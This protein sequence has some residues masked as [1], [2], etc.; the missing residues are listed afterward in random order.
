VPGRPHSLR[1]DS[2]RPHRT[3]QPRLRLR[4]IPDHALLRHSASPLLYGGKSGYR[5]RRCAR[6]YGTSYRKHKKQPH[7]IRCILIQ[8]SPRELI[9][10]FTRRVFLSSFSFFTIRHA[11]YVFRRD[12]FRQPHAVDRQVKYIAVR[13]HS[14]C[15]NLIYDRPAVPAA[16]G[17]SRLI[18]S[19]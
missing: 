17:D 5:R 15:I 13:C 18:I 7:L 11:L 19:R 6:H 3:I 2:R 10:R 1:D 16:Y 8:N 12:S 4:K 14:V 9:T